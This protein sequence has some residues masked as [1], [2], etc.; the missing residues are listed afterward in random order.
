MSFA[1]PQLLLDL[2][3]RHK[4]GAALGIPSICSA[5]RLV[6]EAGMLQA[7]RY[8][9]PL[10]IEATCNQVNPFGGYTGMTPVDFANYVREI[11]G[12]MHFP[13]ERILLGGDH[14]GPFPWQ[15]RPSAQ[16]MQNAVDMARAYVQAGFGKIHLDASMR[17]ADDDPS[18]PFALEVCAQRAASMCRAVEEA[19]AADERLARPVYVIGSEVP[20]P[21]GTQEKEET[22]RATDPADAAQQIA[23]FRAAFASLGLQ[24]AWERVI[25]LVV[26][27]GVEFGDEDLFR[28][29]RQKARRLSQYI[30]TVPGMVYEAH[31]T[32]YQQAAHLRQMVEDHFAILKVGPAL[33]FA[34]R[35]AVFALAHMEAEWLGGRADVTLSGVVEALE[36]AMLRSPKYWQKYYPQE[37]RA[38]AYARKYSLSDRIRYYWNAAQVEAGLQ[39]LL[40]NLEAHPA[41]LTLLSQYMPVQHA[42]ARASAG[43][44]APRALVWEHIGEVLAGYWDA[45]RS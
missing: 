12:Q 40:A 23:A 44:I 3:Q 11:A 19:C 4:Q 9:Q 1:S 13:L 16:A 27:P 8:G 17:C 6:L 7:Q 14:L 2:V 35:E 15:D 10:L 32:D 18:Q 29:D 43:A 42:Q 25:G 45:S 24:G 39:R 37:A 22:L 34:M 30:E 31:S 36:A 33:T 26:Q 41:P 38:A 28:Y 5:N 21:G 20:V